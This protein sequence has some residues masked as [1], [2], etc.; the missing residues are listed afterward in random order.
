MAKEKIPVKTT[1]LIKALGTKASLKKK[2]ASLPDSELKKMR[3]LFN[4]SVTE[5]MNERE[6]KN[7]EVQRRKSIINSQLEALAKEHNIA[8]SEVLEVLKSSDTKA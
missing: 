7:L 3:E 2:L 5:L 4:L 6:Q 1:E 8:P